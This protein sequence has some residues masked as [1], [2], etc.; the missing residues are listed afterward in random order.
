MKKQ[1]KTWR[2]AAAAGLLWLAGTLPAQGQLS[3]LHVE[4]RYLVTAEGERIN[5]HGFCQTYSPWFNEQGSKWSNYDVAGCL[6]YN[7][8]IIDGILAAGWKVDFVRMHMDPYWSNTPGKQVSGESDISAFSMTRFKTYLAEVFIPMAEF[9]VSKG[10]YVVMRPPG[11]CPETISP[12]DAYQ[13]YL[14]RVW[15]Y[16]A[17][18]SKLK[19]N[20]C[21]LFELANEPVRMVL[22]NGAAAS[23]KDVT[24]YFQAVV[25]TLR[26]GGCTN[27]LLVP[28]LGWQSQ[29]KDYA[30]Y[31]ISDSNYGYAIHCYPGWYNGGWGGDGDVSVSYTGFKSGWA[32]Q[33]EP[34]AKTNPIV[35]TEMD[36]APKKY[37]S[38]WGKSVTGVAGGMGFGANFRKLCDDTG[39]VS[40]VLF[41]DGNLLADYDDAAP[42]GAT[43]LTD[44][45]ACPRPCYRW[46]QY[47][48][49]EEYRRSVNPQLSS[50]SVQLSTVAP[51]SAVYDLCGRRVAAGEMGANGLARGVYIIRGRK[52][53]ARG[54]RK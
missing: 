16:V 21:I 1:K 36:W 47:Y 45:Q 39:N 2:L 22:A 10:L 43:F 32:E 48:A 37:N 40:W 4:G 29:Y 5:M 19:R 17:T 30:R 50:V 14:K 3:P 51:S 15:G 8:G 11:V 54:Y 20:G 25:D 12:G 38:S 46:F 18:R 6:A 53:L 49:T 41:T 9:A 34:V 28:G 33:I 35:V 23:G 42:D 52:Y 27:V 44:P 13:A 26:S 7:M 31:P 24:E